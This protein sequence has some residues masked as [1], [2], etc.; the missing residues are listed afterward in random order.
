MTRKLLL[1]LAAAAAF[2]VGSSTGAGAGGWAVTALDPLP[3]PPA[4]GVTT[5]VGFTILQHGRTPAVGL[6][7]AIVL[8]GTRFG[9]REEGDPGHYVA[10]VTF[11]EAGTY[12]WYVEPGW[13][14]PQELGSIT[15]GP[16]RPAADS[17]APWA[18]RWG[19]VSATLLAGLWAA[20]LLRHQRRPEVFS[21]LAVEP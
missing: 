3:V 16:P 7:T 9:A 13:F 19:L 6:D 15:V 18:L 8:D 17:A 20:S 21:P 10:A 5:E 12:D 14:Q 1:A 4:A 2:L 11:P